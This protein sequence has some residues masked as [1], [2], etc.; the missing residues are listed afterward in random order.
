[1][2][3]AENFSD[4]SSS[5]NFGE[6]STQNNM[7]K[8]IRVLWTIVRY[9]NS[10]RGYYKDLNLTKLGFICKFRLKRLHQIDP[11]R[12]KRTTMCNFFRQSCFL[13]LVSSVQ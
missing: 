13:H 9:F 4:K 12:T 7:Y 3:S 8:Y 10:I 1:M 6:I 2:F 5:S 11:R